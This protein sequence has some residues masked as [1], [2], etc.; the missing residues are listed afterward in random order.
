MQSTGLLRHIHNLNLWQP[1]HFRPLTISGHQVGHVKLEICQVLQQWPQYFDVSGTE[2]VFKAEQEGFEQRSQILNEVVRKLVAQGLIAHYLDEPYPITGQSRQQ[3]F[4]I[5][6]RGAA[7]YFGI[8]TY[9]QHLNGY[10]RTPPGMK[11]WLARRAPD[12]LHFPDKLDN[13]V[14]G[15]LPQNLSLQQNLIKECEEE[16]GMPAALSS[17]AIPVGVVSYCRE[18]VAGLKPDTLY[19]YDLELPESFVPQNTDGE[20]AEFKLVDA[21]EALQLV[22]ETDELKLNCNLVFIDFFIRHGIIKPE[23][24]HYLEIIGGLHG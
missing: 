18:T 14:A 4:A 9:G 7:A 5:L 19:C 2:V 22:S 3:Q 13:L 15:G 10:V 16:A 8:R 17:R 6:D 21:D 12:R 11:I 23:H 1:E 24:E 20:V